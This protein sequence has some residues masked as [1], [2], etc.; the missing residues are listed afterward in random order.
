MTAALRWLLCLLSGL[1]L[2]SLNSTSRIVFS[3]PHS[4]LPRESRKYRPI[5]CRLAL[6]FLCRCRFRRRCRLGRR[7][8]FHFRAWLADR[9]RRT[10]FACGTRRAR[11]RRRS[12]DRRGCGWRRSGLTLCRLSSACASCQGKTKNCYQNPETEHPCFHVTTS[13]E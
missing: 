1:G 7:S 10:R 6:D 3:E 4:R 9:R 2:I 11:F 8:R 13:L 5:G 12:R